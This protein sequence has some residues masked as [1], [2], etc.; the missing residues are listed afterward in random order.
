MYL[1]LQN[2]TVILIQYLI[3]LESGSVGKGLITQV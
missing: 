2:W 3:E 1:Y